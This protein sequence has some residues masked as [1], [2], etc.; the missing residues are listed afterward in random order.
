M[1]SQAEFRMIRGQQG[2]FS[3]RWLIEESTGQLPRTG[4]GATGPGEPGI[5]LAQDTDTRDG[6]IPAGAFK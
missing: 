5:V 4:P 3:G 1:E 2:I 6:I